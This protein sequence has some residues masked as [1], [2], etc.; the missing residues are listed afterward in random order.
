MSTVERTVVLGSIVYL[1]DKGRTRRADC[2]TV[3]QVNTADLERFD[4]LNVLLPKPE[5]APAADPDPVG[6]TID[7]NAA[8]DAEDAQPAPAAAADLVY[9]PADEDGEP[10]TD[11]PAARKR[12]GTLRVDG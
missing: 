12:R 4:R 9:E 10:D 1:D 3:V 5:P 6:E 2:G 8:D 7:E 11:R